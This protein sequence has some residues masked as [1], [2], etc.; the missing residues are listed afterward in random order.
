MRRTK[1]KS[2]DDNDN[3]HSNPHDY[4]IDKV[5]DIEDIDLI[6]SHNAYDHILIEDASEIFRQVLLTEN[7]IE[8]ILQNI[9][10]QSGNNNVNYIHSETF[11]FYISPEIR[12]NYT[13]ESNYNSSKPMKTKYD[14]LL[15]IYQKKIYDKI[16]KNPRMSIITILGV[17]LGYSGGHFASF[18]YNNGE[19]YIFDSMQRIEGS[20]SENIKSAGYYTPYFE[21]LAKDIFVGANVMVPNCISSELTVQ[22]TGGFP[23]NLPYKVIIS[24]LPKKNKELIS[25]QSTENQ[26]H[27]CYLWSI[28]WLHLKITGYNFEQILNNSKNLDPLIIIKRYGWCLV[29]NLRLFDYVEESNK[30]YENFY[31][32]HFLSIWSNVPLNDKLSINFGRYKI[33]TPKCANMNQAVAES[34]KHVDV[35]LENNTAVPNDLYQSLCQ[36]QQRQ[37]RKK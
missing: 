26:N 23:Q 19:V 5:T 10:D 27:F 15:N 31:D 6:C 22:Y 3:V 1:R 33:P 29:K 12:S 37:K 28:W 4:P 36:K 25:L 34:I 18:Y 24:K 14:K 30:L 16:K 17:D 21:Q 11:P 32:R 13:E 9:I 35:M 7:V 8:T 20:Y 2:F